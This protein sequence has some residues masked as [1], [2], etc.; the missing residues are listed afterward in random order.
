MYIKLNDFIEF[1]NTEQS[2]KA[3]SKQNVQD[4]KLRFTTVIT[5]KYTTVKCVFSRGLVNLMLKHNLERFKMLINPD[6][7]EIL[8]RLDHS[9]S[10]HDLNLHKMQ[11]SGKTINDKYITYTMLPLLESK[12]LSSMV[13]TCEHDEGLN[14]ILCKPSKKGNK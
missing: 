12:K 4:V 2:K 1:K 13:Y 10:A 8:I 6:T 7:S 5:S 9:T 14:L 3:I 11:P